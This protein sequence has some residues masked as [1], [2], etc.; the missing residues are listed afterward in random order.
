VDAALFF[1][2]IWYVATVGPLAVTYFSPRHLY[3]PSAGVAIA[4]AALFDPLTRGRGP[5]V[6]RWAGAAA[7][8][9]LAANLAALQ[10]HIRHWNDAARVSHALI[11]EVH[12]VAAGA[13]DGSLLGIDVTWRTREAFVW[14]WAV[15]FTVRPP[16]AREDLTARLHVVGYSY[17]YC[18]PQRAWQR[19]VR[20]QLA[21]WAAS[22]GPVF[23]VGV[24]APDPTTHLAAPRTTDVQEAFAAVAAAATADEADTRLRE[25]FQRAYRSEP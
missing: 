5:A 19:T 20:E 14:G 7:A 10:A 15:P 6:R 9:L 2:P 24:M 1:G 21:R 22:P 16:F 11:G 25:A 18:C 13:P 17:T 23:V 8:V 4:V 3:F 12:R